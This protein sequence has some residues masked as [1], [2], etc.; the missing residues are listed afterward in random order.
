MNVSVAEL[1]SPPGK[2]MSSPESLETLQFDVD[3][4]F[5]DRELMWV[6]AEPHVNE[7]YQRGQFADTGQFLSQREDPKLTRITAQYSEEGETVGFSFSGE[8]AATPLFQHEK[9]EET[10]GKLIPVSV[11]SWNGVGV[12]QGD[13]VASWGTE[14]IG[15]PVR[16]VAVS[17]DN[18]RYVENNPDLGKIGFADGFPLLI[19]GKESVDQV[20]TWLMERDAEP[21]PANRFRA[22]ILLD[23]LDAFEEDYI[24]RLSVVVDGLAM[25]LRRAKACGRCPIPDTNQKTGERA[26]EVRSVLGKN[27]RGIH[28]GLDGDKSKEIMFGQNFIID[29]PRYLPEGEIIRLRT[30]SEIEAV[31]STKTNWQ[32]A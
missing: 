3:G 25:T 14:V 19:V 4:L 30:G 27:R 12:D 8:E 9:P 23:G 7:L 13:E 17:R 6:E 32:P 24:E 28:L 15:R 18:P 16:L 11:W 31:M 26:R 5:G 21:V 1:W 2:S 10:A 22:N 20:N 29:M